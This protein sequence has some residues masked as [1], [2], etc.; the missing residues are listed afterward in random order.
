MVRLDGAE[1]MLLRSEVAR[2]YLPTSHTFS[3][4]CAFKDVAGET[5]FFSMGEGR[6]RPVFETVG[7]KPSYMQRPLDLLLYLSP[8]ICRSSS[9][10][11]PVLGPELVV[12]GAMKRM[13]SSMGD[14]PT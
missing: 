1:L 8:E 4:N 10:G 3:T 9:K 11:F 6:Y 2:S 13:W 5:R 12:I 14:K 7:A